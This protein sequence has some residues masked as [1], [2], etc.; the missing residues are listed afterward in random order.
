VKIDGRSRF[1]SEKILS[2]KF[3]LL[4]KADLSYL[5]RATYRPAKKM[6]EK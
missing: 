4:S 2:G 6:E 3:N 1:E 5:Q